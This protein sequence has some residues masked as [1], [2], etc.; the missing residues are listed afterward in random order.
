MRVWGGGAARR[1]GAGSRSSLRAGSRGGAHA[2]LRMEQRVLRIQH[3]VTLVD[4]LNFN[5][6]NYF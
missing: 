2:P 1:A 4:S 6:H 5:Q 3:Q